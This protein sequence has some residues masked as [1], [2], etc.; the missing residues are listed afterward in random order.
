M[1]PLN[2]LEPFLCSSVG[3]AFFIANNNIP[4]RL[5]ELRVSVVRTRSAERGRHFCRRTGVQAPQKP[6][7]PHISSDN[8]ITIWPDLTAGYPII[9]I[10]SK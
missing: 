2:I 9:H 6:A 3:G 7:K 5:A 4:Q 8:V 1:I 10:L